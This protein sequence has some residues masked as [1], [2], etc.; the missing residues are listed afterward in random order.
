MNKAKIGQ[1]CVGATD[2]LE[3]LVINVSKTCKICPRLDLN[4]HAQKGTGPQPAAY[5]I[6]PRGPETRL[7]L[8]SP[9]GHLS[10]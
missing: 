1:P 3:E 5:A 7:L 6:P 10:T 8:Y 4:Q 9:R 2:V